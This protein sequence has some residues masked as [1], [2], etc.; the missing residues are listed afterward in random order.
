MNIL[1]EMFFFFSKMR[2]VDDR[3]SVKVDLPIPHRRA[4]KKFI[5]EIIIHFE[6]A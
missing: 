3:F 2:F 5:L 4:R 6:E 1:S